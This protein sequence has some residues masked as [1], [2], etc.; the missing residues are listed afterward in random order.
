VLGAHP[1]IAR[2]ETLAMPGAAQAAGEVI[3]PL[4]GALLF[5]AGGLVPVYAG[6]AL[7]A[8]LLALAFGVSRSF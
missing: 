6:A 3:A 4:L 1:S 5:V 8:L 7:A 2:P